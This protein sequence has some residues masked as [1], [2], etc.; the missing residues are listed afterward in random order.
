MGT[1]RTWAAVGLWSLLLASPAWADRRIQIRGKGEESR[2]SIEGKERRYV[3]LHAGQSIETEI[4]GP[5]SIVATFRVLFSSAMPESVTYRTPVAVD[6]EGARK[7]RRDTRRSDKARFVEKTPEWTLGKSNKISLLIPEGSHVVR[8]GPLS[9]AKKRPL[10]AVVSFLRE[11]SKLPLTPSRY[12]WVARDRYRGKDRTW[13]GVTPRQP[14]SLE[15]IGPT[16]LHVVSSLD[17]GPGVRGL[18][19]Y[20]LNLEVDGSP[21]KTWHLKAEK[22]EASSYEE[23]PQIVPGNPNKSTLPIA[24]GKH[25]IRVRLSNTLAS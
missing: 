15:I 6:G 24:K 8:W 17:F 7:H 25:R 20:T 14:V 21:A 23:R 12:A 10:E 4:L 22:S 11:K 18:Q 5:A 13:Y 19:A 2:L 3:R 9:D 16:R 1:G